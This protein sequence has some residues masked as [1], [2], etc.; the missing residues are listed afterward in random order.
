[1]TAR[2]YLGFDYGGK[3][4]GV[5]VGSTQSGLAQP[6]AT[7]RVS[8]GREP[9][10]DQ[11]ARLIAEWRPHALVVGLPLHMDG[12]EQAM[13]RAA[14][15]FGERLKERYNLPLHMVDE[16]L[17][18]RAAKDQLYAAGVA[19]TRHKSRLD[20]V[21]AQT[22]LQSFLDT[23]DKSTQQKETDANGR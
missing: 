23:H 22:I 10:W 18:T 4:I 11:I 20:K 14:R 16:R 9:D 3:F 8:A 19:G 17:T 21:A 15:A 1:V 5:A 6:V 12:S 7:V 13:T 2:V